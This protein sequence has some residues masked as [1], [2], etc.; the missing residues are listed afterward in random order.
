M[1]PE[2]GPNRPGTPDFLEK[3]A[4][5][6]YL[7]PLGNSDENGKKSI[8]ESLPKTGRMRILLTNDDGVLS[9]VLYRVAEALSGE[10]DIVV[11]APDTDQSGKSHSF[12][13]GPEK[14]LT[15]R[16]DA[17]VPYPLFAVDGTPSDCIKFAITHLFRDRRPELVLSGLDIVL[18]R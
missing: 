16:Q 5:P 14:L 1:A 15:Y 9:P 10:H 18:G 7:L 17:T 2:R 8:P 3:K 4:N 12:T 11:V 13:H 6:S